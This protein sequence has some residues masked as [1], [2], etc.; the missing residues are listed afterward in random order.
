MGEKHEQKK[1]KRFL[2]KAE[3]QTF[4]GTLRKTLNKVSRWKKKRFD[5]IHR[6]L[7]NNFMVIHDKK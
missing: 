4:T 3:R 1:T 2:K 6:L 5:G 7:S